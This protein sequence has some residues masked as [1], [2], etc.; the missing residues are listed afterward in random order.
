MTPDSPMDS[1]EPFESA[2]KLGNEAAKL[3]RRVT[4]AQHRA[5]ERLV[6]SG[7]R[8]E[9]ELGQD[10]VMTI[11]VVAID[12]QDLVLEHQ[13]C[14]PPNVPRNAGSLTRK[15]QQ[16]QEKRPV[17]GSSL[18]EFIEQLRRSTSIAKLLPEQIKQS[19]FAGARG[20]FSRMF[21]AQIRKERSGLNLFGS[22]EALS[23]IGPRIRITGL[24]PLQSKQMIRWGDRFRPNGSFRLEHGSRC[25]RQFPIRHPEQRVDG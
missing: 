15:G 13:D 23:A 1:I 16:F 19:S 7:C 4:F 3:D 20:S 2:A 6:P 8:L 9:T 18:K 5:D 22:L 21:H 17:K 10:E 11:Q 12:S 25:C 14:K 24:T